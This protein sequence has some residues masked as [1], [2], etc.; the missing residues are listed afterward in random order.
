MKLVQPLLLTTTVLCCFFIQ[1]CDKK[2]THTPESTLAVREAV[3]KYAISSRT[4]VEVWYIDYDKGNDPP[5]EFLD[6]FSDL[7]VKVGKASEA[8]K[9]KNGSVFKTKTGKQGYIVSA[10]IIK[11]IDRKT[12]KVEYN[13]Y[14]GM[15]AASGGK[16]TARYENGKWVIEIWERWES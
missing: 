15:E 2:M 14:H 12:A 13:D 6:R 5:S 10:K 11:W 4:G 16:G 7:H 1:G 8:V 9:D 3:F